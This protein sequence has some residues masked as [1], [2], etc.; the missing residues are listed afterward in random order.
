MGWFW[1]RKPVD[2]AAS[3]TDPRD[4]LLSSFFELEK[5]RIERNAELE[6]K[7][8]EADVKRAELEL[9]E[10]ERIGDEKRRDQLFKTELKEKQRAIAQ[11]ARDAKKEKAARVAAAHPEAVDCEECAALVGGREPRHS[12][13]LIRHNLENHRQRFM[14]N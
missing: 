5:V 11:K 9:A 6:A 12:S 3:I 2:N 4:T 14:A 7:R 8:H 1:K 13:D 10:L